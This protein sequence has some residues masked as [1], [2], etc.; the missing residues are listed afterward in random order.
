MDGYHSSS[1][2]ALLLITKSAQ[3]EVCDNH[4]TNAANCLFFGET[5]SINDE[6]E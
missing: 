6:W 5:K 3:F 1:A 2:R 4:R